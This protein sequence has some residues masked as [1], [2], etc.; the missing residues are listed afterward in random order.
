MIKW[1]LILGSL[2]II[3]CSTDNGKKNLPECLQSKIDFFLKNN[4]NQTPK[5]SVEMYLYKG[6]EV[7][8]LNFQNFPDGQSAVISTEC[9]SI[10]SLGGFDGPLNDCNEFSSAQFIETI[11]TDNR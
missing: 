1:V 3:S 2:F 4:K 11:W 6:N 7:Y 5:A 8:V 9:E 10:C